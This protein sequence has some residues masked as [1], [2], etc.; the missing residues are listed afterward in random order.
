MHSTRK[1][2]SCRTGWVWNQCSSNRFETPSPDPGSGFPMCFQ[3][4]FED[5]L[6]FYSLFR[7]FRCNRQGKLIWIGGG[8]NPEQW[9]EGCK[10]STF[11][12]G[13]S[14]STAEE[15]RRSDDLWSNDLCGGQTAR[16]S[17]P[18]EKKEAA[19]KCEG[20]SCFPASRLS[21]Q[22]TKEVRN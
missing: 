7:R 18:P 2:V 20:N 3:G 19:K 1:G 11:F 14:F 21:P 17:F 22:L 13:S 4:G 9:D 16:S 8:A 6:C 12:L 10:P 15:N 5:F